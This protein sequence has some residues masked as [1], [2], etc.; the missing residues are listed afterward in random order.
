MVP[1]LIFLKN[2][3]L[4]QTTLTSKSGL[5][6]VTF[7]CWG[8]WDFLME[9]RTQGLLLILKTTLVTPSFYALGL[10]FKN[11]F[12]LFRKLHDCYFIGE[13]TANKQTK[14]YLNMTNQNKLWIIL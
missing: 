9:P 3:Y 13:K 10:P 7:S 2:I 8:W 12:C 4:F 14:Y 11:I 6:L 5:I 1:G